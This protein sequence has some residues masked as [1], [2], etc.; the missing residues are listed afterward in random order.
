Q[1]DYACVVKFG[2]MLAEI[3]GDVQYGLAAFKFLK[4]HHVKVEFLG[5]V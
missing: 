3:N 5:Y 1:M 2:V 4:V